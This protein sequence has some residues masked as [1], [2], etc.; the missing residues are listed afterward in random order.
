MKKTAFF[1]SPFFWI[2][3]LVIS[4]A[5]VV[6]L[7]FNFEKA[8]PIVNISVEMN[9]D[10]ALQKAAQL[11]KEF[12]LGPEDF[13]EAASFKNDTRFQNYTELEGGGLETFNQTIDDNIYQSY[14]WK[15]RHFKEKEVNEVTFSFAPSGEFYGF[16]EKLAEDIPGA[17]L[18]ADSALQIATA[19]AEKWKVDM[20][21]YHLVE[22]SLDQKTGGRIDHKFVY[23]R[24]DVKV[25]ES[26]FRIAIQVSG[27][28]VTSIRHFVKIPDDFDR[29][30]A[31]MRS[32][33]D[34][35]ATIGQSILFLL[36]GLIGV[37]LGIFFLLKRRFILWKKALYW[38]IGIGLGVGLLDVLNAMPML[39]F[40]YDT[41]EAAGSFMG[42]QL[43]YGLLNTLLM[44]GIVFISALA[45][46]GLTRFLYPEKIQFWKLWGPQAGGSKQVLGQTAGAYL[47]VPVFLALDVL[48]YLVTTHYL[49]WWNPAG[50]LS[51]PDILAQNLPWFSSIAISTQAGFWEEIICRAVP[52]AGV[53]LLVRNLKTK[54]LWMILTLFAQT[55]IFGSLHANYPQSPSYAR[56]LEM[57]IPFLIFGLIYLRFG[58]L[59]VIIAHFAVDV[60]WISLPL[61]VANAPG[62]WFDR[63]VIILLLFVPLWIVLYW[64]MKNKKWEEVPD[65]A[66]NGSW[67]PAVKEGAEEEKVSVQEEV[68]EQSQSDSKFL[69][70]KWLI[71]AAVVGLVL[72]GFFTFTDKNQSPDVETYR[73]EAIAKAKATLAGQFNFDPAGWTVLTDLANSPTMAHK[74]VWREF[75]SDYANL[76][77]TFLNPPSWIIRFVKLDAPVEDRAEEYLARVGVDGTVLSYRHNWPEKRE[78]ESLSQ[79]TA[80]LMAK[81]ALQN[82]GVANIDGLKLVNIKPSKL[83]ARTDWSIEFADTVNYQLEEGQG[84]YNVSI[85]GNEV[86]GL[87]KYVFVPENWER[88]YDKSNSSLHIFTLISNLFLYAIIIFGVVMG[89][90]N[91]S[92]KRFSSRMFW[93]FVVTFFVLS[94][95]NILNSWNTVTANYYTGLPF[96]NFITMT[97]IGGLIG[98]IFLS[99]GVGVI[100][101]FSCEMARRDSNTAQPVLK[102]VLL[103]I[104]LTGI[105]TLKVGWV[106]QLAPHWLSIGNIND[107]FSVFGFT[108][109]QMQRFVFN[110]AF[111][112]IL[113]YLIGIFTNSYTRRRALG[114]TFIF[115]AGFLASG[116]GA[117]SVSSWIGIGLASGLIFILLFMLLKNH[118]SWMPIIFVMSLLLRQIESL[119]LNQFNGVIM[120]AIL[121]LLVWGFAAYVWYRGII[122]CNYSK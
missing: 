85:A 19:G 35:I 33:N 68:N 7:W 91:W 110:P 30:Y 6:F 97:L 102:A 45:G 120:G 62:I 82:F 46:E 96:S 51:D 78:S 23:E 111:A 92:R 61:W 71:P 42:Q 100:G 69:S 90:I 27:D 48:Y 15:V 80:L 54:N 22:K 76:Q 118:L 57:V 74:F 75:E 43:L 89:F 32:A 58:L 105:Q 14:Q 116:V 56:V 86:N 53:Y 106:E 119:W 67:K 99:M 17:A 3:L 41:S 95:L 13:R 84:R 112:M 101:G 113:F 108:F 60:F 2:G 81:T 9:R 1:R 26:K 64:R 36:Y 66:L 39:W 83:D 87:K 8:N 37:G 72:W 40:D 5:S 59:P 25:N 73:T 49:G 109:D 107:Q 47:F 20:A 114:I 24:D 103:G 117:N 38:A 65:E 34:L 12:K 16:T 115:V 88:D 93:M 70:L 55:I 29:R 18:D 63:V 94:A 31:E 11:A 79:D 77:G 10:E 50:T 122:K 4:V 98:I 104:L 21:S 121:S 44:G 52:L 28:K